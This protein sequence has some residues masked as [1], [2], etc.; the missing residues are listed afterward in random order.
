[1]TKHLRSAGP[2]LPRAPRL[3]ISDTV[4]FSTVIDHA[5]SYQTSA[6]KLFT[7]PKMSWFSVA[8]CRSLNPD[9][10]RKLI[11]FPACLQG[12]K[13][14]KNCSQG[15]KKQQTSTPTSITND[16]CEH[17]VFAIYSI[18]K[19]WSRS[20]GRLNFE[21]KIGATSGLETSPKINWNFKPRCLS[22]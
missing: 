15:F 20:L 6:V 14:Q 9:P 10:P 19:P 21:S 11:H 22:K 7:G 3:R 12:S 4:R 17:F 13:H 8:T 1:M 16:F 5:F 2:C 18:Q